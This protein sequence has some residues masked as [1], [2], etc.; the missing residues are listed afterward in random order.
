MLDNIFCLLLS[1]FRNG[2]PPFSVPTQ[3]TPDHA[4]LAHSPLFP[5]DGMERR[6]GGTEGKDHGLREEQFTGNS[7]KIR[8]QTVTTT[9][10][11]DCT[12]EANDSHVSVHHAETGT[13][14]LHTRTTTHSHYWTKLR[15]LGSPYC[16]LLY[17]FVLTLGI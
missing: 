10:I 14:Q 4:L 3:N 2:I 15:L 12:K 17:L 16:G 8:Q 6:T 11:I 5:C 1:W 7:N 9:L 13:T